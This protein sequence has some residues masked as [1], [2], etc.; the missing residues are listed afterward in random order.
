MKSRRH[1]LSTFL[2]FH[3]LR[4]TLTTEKVCSGDGEPLECCVNNYEVNGKCLECPDGWLGFNC[5]VPCTDDY[6]GRFC[7]SV[8]NCSSEYQCHHVNGCVL[9]ST[10]SDEKIEP[11]MYNDDENVVSTWVL[12][13]VILITLLICGSGTAVAIRTARKR[14]FC[15]DVSTP[16]TFTGR[17][18]IEAYS[19]QR[20]SKF[21][22]PKDISDDLQ[23]AEIVRDGTKSKY[24]TDKSP[25]K[26]ENNYFDQNSSEPKSNGNIYSTHILPDADYDKLQFHPPNDEVLHNELDLYDVTVQ[27][28]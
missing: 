11:N 5:S 13:L 14:N 17:K 19:I 7:V 6:Y 1:G 28:S 3:V 15:F 24:N 8:C 10:V 23:Y 25:S 22:E 2:I 18:T 12:I 26:S 21:N 27:K 9:L 4:C 16:V 20:L